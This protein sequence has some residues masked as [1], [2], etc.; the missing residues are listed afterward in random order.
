MALAEPRPTPFLV[1]VV[2]DDPKLRTRLAMQLGESA[3]SA[4]FSSI[5]ALGERFDSGEPMVVVFGPTYADAQGLARIEQLSRTRPE[6]GSILVAEEISTQLLQQSLRAGVRDV[7]ASPNDPAQLMEAVERVAYTLSAIPVRQ[8]ASTPEEDATE[9]G[10]VI[11]VFS[12]KGGAGKSVV[13]TNLA[14]LLARKSTR[15]VVLVDADLQ[16]GDIAVM[17]KLTPQHTVVD[18]VSAM[19]RLDAQLLQ[20]LL[21]RHDSS[22]V[23]VLPAPLEPAFADQVSAADLAKIVQVLK[24]FASY[25]VIDTP[26]QFNDVVIALIEHSDDILMVAGLDIPNIKNTKLGLQTLRLLEVGEEKLTLLLNRADSKVQLDVGEVERTLG[27]RAGCLVPSDIAVPQSVN[28]GVPVVLDAPRSEVARA[29]EGLAERFGGA[30]VSP[31][32]ARK[33]RALF[34]RA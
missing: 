20:S 1:A 23:L 15:P 6:L 13:A 25:V 24:T 29:F 7:V 22:G 4:S 12:T 16:F 11:T 30:A 34:G 10:R 21:V 14:V 27:L 2:D 31:P 3:R 17:L 18:A 33:G 8:T 5:D 19:Q 32:P 9:P 28:K 26:A